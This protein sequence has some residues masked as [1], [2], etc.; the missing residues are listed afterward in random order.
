V[1][2]GSCLDA[3]IA[4]CAAVIMADQAPG[5]LEARRLPARLVDACGQ[6]TTVAGWPK[7]QAIPVEQ[8]GCPRS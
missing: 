2:A 4:S 5:W 3:N 7:E 1:A 6:V 8:C